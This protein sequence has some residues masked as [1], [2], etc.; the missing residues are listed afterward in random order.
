[1]T[2]VQGKL[3]AIVSMVEQAKTKPLSGSVVI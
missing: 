3:D 2:D 1:M